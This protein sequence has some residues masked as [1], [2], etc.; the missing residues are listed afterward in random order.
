MRRFEVRHSSLL[1][2]G[3]LALVTTVW[4]AGSAL[5]AA[6]ANPVRWVDDDAG[7]GGGPAACATAPFTSIQAAIDASGTWDRVYVCPGTYTEQLTLDVKGVLVKSVPESGA[8][9]ATPPVMTPADGLVT[10]VRMPAWAARL[11]GFHL[12]LN[13]GEPAPGFGACTHVDVAVLATGLRTRVR[14]NTIDSVGSATLSGPC[15]YDYGIVFGQHGVVPTVSPF[16]GR[17]VNRAQGNTVTDFKVGGILVEGPE[18]LVRVSGNTVNYFHADDSG[19]VATLAPS[20]NP[21]AAGYSP[22]TQVNS[23]FSES[24]GIGVESGAAAS[25]R[26]NHVATS[27]ITIAT[28]GPAS[29]AWGIA[30]QVAAG[31]TLVRDNTVHAGQIGILSNGSH[32]A[33][34]SGNTV[35]PGGVE[36]ILLLASNNH[37]VFGNTVSG[38]VY[39]ISVDSGA[40]GNTIH[41]NDLRGNSYKDCYDLTAGSGTAGSANSWTNNLAL[42][43]YPSGLCAIGGGG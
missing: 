32:G 14:N 20:I 12:D 1:R 2:L 10:L 43:E 21:C 11:I 38:N 26:N 13:A 5:P 42:S 27:A 33:E 22:T 15:G 34:I 7:A 3:S 37:D 39:G 24:F 16:N 9:I 6:A 29:L 25:V 35:L 30:L 8:H 41:D 31:A 17:S 40:F 28:S 23:A 4:L 18:Y 36:G 19:C